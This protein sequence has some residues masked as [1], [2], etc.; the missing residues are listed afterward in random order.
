MLVRGHLCVLMGFLWISGLTGL[1]LGLY[2]LGDYAPMRDQVWSQFA[3][4]AVVGAAGCVSYARTLVDEEDAATRNTMMY[5]SSGLFLLMT[6]FALTNLDQAHHEWC[7]PARST[8][9]ITG[10]LPR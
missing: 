10:L 2:M 9:R 6:F 3:R 7:A 4:A 1:T 5:V 8:P